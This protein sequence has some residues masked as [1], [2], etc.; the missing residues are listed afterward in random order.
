MKT[1]CRKDALFF[2]YNACLKQYIMLCLVKTIL[3]EG[4]MQ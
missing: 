3:K 1:M 2:L 4:K